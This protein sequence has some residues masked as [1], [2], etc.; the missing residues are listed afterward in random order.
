VR[1]IFLDQDQIAINPF[2]VFSYRIQGEISGVKGEAIRMV[3][4]IEYD[5]EIMLLNAKKLVVRP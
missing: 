1:H 4:D 5:A 3:V 2:V